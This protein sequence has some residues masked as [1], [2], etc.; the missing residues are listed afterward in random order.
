MGRNKKTKL[1]NDGEEPNDNANANGDVNETTGLLTNQS[2][3]IENQPT[4]NGNDETKVHYK[5]NTT[6][7]TALEDGDSN[8]MEPPTALDVLTHHQSNPP[9]RP[10]P[11]EFFFPL[12]NPTVQ[13][14]YRFTVTPVTPFAVLH[15]RPLDGPMAPRKGEQ[16]TN[17]NASN[18]GGANNSPDKRDNVTGLLRRSAVLPSHGTD[19]SGRWILV[20]VG[21][22]SGWARKSDGVRVAYNP[23]G[24]ERVKSFFANEGWM[25]NHVFLFNGRI[26]LGSDAPLFFVTNAMISVSLLIYFFVI[27]PHLYHYEKL[28]ESDGKVHE[29]V[30]QWTTHSV[31][32]Y[33]MIILSIGVF[34]TLWTCATTDP[35]ILPSVSCPVKAPIPS[36]PG[37]TIGGPLGFRYCSTCNIFRPPRSK[38]CNSCNVCVSKFDQ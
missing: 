9:R 22:R 3:T 25:G 2:P 11:N 1:L 33:V 38:H 14:Y 7:E 15:K 31:T 19:P 27:L 13:T 24:F 16:Q 10:T 29:T 20:S 4:S 28:H 26:M 17:G 36:G 32:V 12:T 21:G 30:M 8:H 35:G 6:T 34:Y 5:Y 18:G 23:T 37:T